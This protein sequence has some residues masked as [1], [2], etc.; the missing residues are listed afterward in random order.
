MIEL[1]TGLPGAAKTL[2]VVEQLSKMLSRWDKHPE[3]ARPI[4]V[5]G[6]ADLALPHAPLPLKEIV[7]PV[8][9]KLPSRLVPDWG[10][11]P[12]GAYVVIDEAQGFFPPR[13]SGAAVPEHVEFLNTHRHHGLD[14]VMITQHPKLVDSAVRALVGKHQHFRRMFGGARSVVYEWDACSDN[15][16][17][18]KNAV[19][20]YYAFPRKAF[21]WYRSAEVHT[22]Q[23]FKVPRW[24]VVP[25]IGLGL[26]AFAVPSAYNRIQAMHERPDVAL[27]TVSS[28][29]GAAAV[30]AAAHAVAAS[31]ASLP[32]SLSASSVASSRGR[33]AGCMAMGERCSC[34]DIDGW[35]VIVEWQMC[36]VSAASYAG[37]VPLSVKPEP[38][39]ARPVAKASEPVASNS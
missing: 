7:N 39:V 25:F 30:G 29:A 10:A 20:S 14:I 6:V 11:V 13:A 34:V 19:T 32:P 28:K 5:H 36:K 21:E 16:N 27:A 24:V 31:A 26:C 33:V 1:R 17:G 35:P 12:A 4:F 18:F 9:P 8:S 37:L 2:S 15:L 22:K 3:E 23:K 38:A